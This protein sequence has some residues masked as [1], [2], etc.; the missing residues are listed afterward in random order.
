[1]LEGALMW[2]ATGENSA[3]NESGPPMVV[4]IGEHVG[5]VFNRLNPSLKQGE[6]R[7]FLGSIDDVISGT[8]SEDIKE[9]IGIGTA[10][11]TIVPPSETCAPCG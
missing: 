11:A 1:M 6:R 3:T 9:P 7:Q 5:D 10:L 8:L 4:P 2:D